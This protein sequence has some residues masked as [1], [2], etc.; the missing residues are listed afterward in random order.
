MLMR[1]SLV[2]QTPAIGVQNSRV[3]KQ[4]SAA[5]PFND[6]RVEGGR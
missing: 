4:Q 5:V 1:D 6:M 2:Q 3:T